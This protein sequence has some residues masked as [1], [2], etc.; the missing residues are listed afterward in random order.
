MLFRSLNASGPKLVDV[1]DSATE[2]NTE[3]GTPDLLEG[4]YLMDDLT[5]EGTEQS[6]YLITSADDLTLMANNINNGIGTSAYYKL[7]NNIDLNGKEWT[8]IGYHDSS[9]GNATAFSGTFDGGNYTVSN[10]V[11]TKANTDYIGFFG[12]V[13]DGTIKNLNIDNAVIDFASS[14][15][16]RLYVGVV[17]GRLITTEAGSLASITHCN[18]TNSS[19]KASSHGTIRAG[20]IAGIAISGRFENSRVLLA[21]LNA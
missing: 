12:L 2:L 8:P 7:T 3:F 14:S 15:T 17:V 4:A 1:A 13:T 18:V 21:F 10:F 6:P 9:K 19:V 16:Q 5:G 11:I 20:G